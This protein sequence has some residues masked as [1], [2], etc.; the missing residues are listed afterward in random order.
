MNVI[1]FVIVFLRIFVS[2][3]LALSIILSTGKE[4]KMFKIRL[5]LTITLILLWVD[6]Y[7]TS[8]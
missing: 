1:H 2:L 6:N 4:N 7:G 3:I 8:I 5:L